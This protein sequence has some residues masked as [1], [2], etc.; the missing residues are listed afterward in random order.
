[1]VAALSP[2]CRIPVMGQLVRVIAPVEL[3]VPTSPRMVP[4]VHVAPALARTRKF[5]AAASVSLLTE[6]PNEGDMRRD[7]GSLH[8]A[9]SNAKATM[10]RR[11]Y[12]NMVWC[13]V[14]S[15]TEGHRITAH[16]IGLI[17]VNPHRTNG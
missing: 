12:E 4:S 7:E 15:G 8:A 5:D 13:S 17:A 14:R 9:D 10:A 6:S 11:L 3:N 2:T 1:C 16:S